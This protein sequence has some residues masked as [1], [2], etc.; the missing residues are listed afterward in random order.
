MSY[1]K[2]FSSEIIISLYLII[3]LL[4]YAGCS[5]PVSGD[6]DYTSYISEIQEWHKERIESLKDRDGVLSVMGLFWLKEGE[7]SF[8]SHP[9]ND[10]VLPEGVSPEFIGSFILN[11]G[12][13]RIKVRP[14]IKV[15][16]KGKAISEMVLKSDIESD[17]TLLESGRLSWFIIN[18]NEGSGVR[19]RDSENPRIHQFKGIETFEVDPDWKLE[20]SF[21]AY[22]PARLITTV[23]A[24]GAER[25]YQSPGALI[26]SMN[27]NTYILDPISFS[28]TGRY[29]V[30][31]GDMTNGEET[32]GGGR[33][34][35]VERPEE[36]GTTILDFNKAI[37]P[38]CAISEFFV[39]PMP[40]RQNRLNLKIIAGEKKYE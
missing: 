36:D 20:A 8:G 14:G 16:C 4:V 37:N 38:P 10:I 12:E 3:S 1:Y 27:N 6:K 23:T 15:T 35:Y 31:F 11:D 19:F 13:V 25:K 40:P 33:F 18:R 32:Y 34:L 29:L 2:I 9:A 22:D 30:I 28:D 26:F 39:C 21:E 17:M 7:N 24:Y 5:S